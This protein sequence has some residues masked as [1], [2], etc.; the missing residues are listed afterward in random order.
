MNDSNHQRKSLTPNR[1]HNLIHFANDDNITSNHQFDLKTEDEIVSNRFQSHQQQ[2]NY[3]AI[4]LNSH[5]TNGKSSNKHRPINRG[6]RIPFTPGQVQELETKFNKT[7]YLSS[8]EVSQLAKRLNLSDTRVSL[9]I[10]L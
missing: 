2:Y 8:L 4:I 10:F 9:K 5:Q 7:Q 6:P 3:Q 1:Y